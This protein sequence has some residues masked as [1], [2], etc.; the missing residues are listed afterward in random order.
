MV[1]CHEACGADVEHEAATV[2]MA[3]DMLSSAREAQ[4]AETPY[5]LRVQCP[6]SAC[7]TPMHVRP[8]PV[9]RV[10]RRL[11][12]LLFLCSLCEPDVHTAWRS[13]GRLPSHALRSLKSPQRQLCRRRDGAPAPAP[14]PPPQ[15]YSAVMS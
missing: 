10:L 2:A 6:L 3:A 13:R 11:R 7:M 15:N 5:E 14:P 1:G 12:C 9:P 4:D 8:T